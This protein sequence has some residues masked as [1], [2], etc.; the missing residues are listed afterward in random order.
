MF[1][2]NIL[3]FHGY[4]SHKQMINQSLKITD[5]AQGSGTLSA[6]EAAEAALVAAAAARQVGQEGVVR[7][8][9]GP[10]QYVHCIHMYMV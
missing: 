2:C 7:G 3:I 4:V 10:W 6:M 1:N 9:R 8:L 5:T